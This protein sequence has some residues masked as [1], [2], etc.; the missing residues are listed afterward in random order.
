MSDNTSIWYSNI[1]LVL[2]NFQFV[3]KYII[4]C[5]DQSVIVSYKSL[6]FYLSVVTCVCCSEKEPAGLPQSE[7]DAIKL[8][9]E[10]VH[11]VGGRAETVKQIPC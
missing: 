10:H 1:L 3:S 9:E 5:G 8:E 11:Q 7:Q 4:D 2:L 6:V